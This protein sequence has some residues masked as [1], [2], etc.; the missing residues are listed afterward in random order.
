MKTKTPTHQQTIHIGLHHSK[1]ILLK[2]KTGVRVVIMTCNMRPDDWGGRCQA[3]W[4]QDF[5]FKPPRAKSKGKEKARGKAGKRKR[6]G[7]DAAPIL[8]EEPEEEEEEG[9]DIGKK[10]R[11]GESGVAA[12]DDAGGAGSG[13]KRKRV[14]SDS[15]EDYPEEEEEEE[16]GEGDD[17]DVVITSEFE[18]ILID[19]FEHVGGPAA[20]WGRSLSAYDFSSANVTLIPSVPGRHKGKDLYRY[21]H[22]R[23][24]AVL[25]REEVHVRPGSHRVAFQAASI[26]NLSRRPYKWLGE[27]TESFMAE[28]TSSKNG[29]DGKKVIRDIDVGLAEEEEMR[30][31]KKEQNE[32]NKGENLP[33]KP[34]G[35]RKDPWG[36]KGILEKRKERADRREAI[37]RRNVLGILPP[38]KPK[39]P[40][41]LGKKALKRKKKEELEA[42]EAAALIKWVGKERK[43]NWFMK[44]LRVVWPTEEAVRTSNLGWESGS[45]MPCLTTTLYEGGYRKCETNYQLNRVMEELKP[46]LCT[47]TGAKGMNRGNAM[48][49]LN[50]YYRYRELPRTDGSLKMSKDGLAYF[51]L[52]SHSLHRIAWGYLEHRNPPQRPRKRRV[53]MKPIYPP[54]PDNTLPYKEEEAQLDIK[55][56]DMGVMFLPSKI[57]PKRPL[58]MDY[59]SDD[60]DD[61]TGMGAAGG[62]GSGA[63]S[64]APFSCD[65]EG[66]LFRLRPLSYRCPDQAPAAR[67]KTLPLGLLP[68]PHQL[69]G[70]PA[71]GV[72]IVFVPHTPVSWRLACQDVWFAAVLLSRSS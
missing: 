21:G 44:F 22:M 3:A 6:V 57:P 59:D 25:A 70:E 4:Y 29:K 43:R 14:D 52:A 58:P 64:P 20:V 10:K 46:L 33:K 72:G 32:R 54:K 24:R 65:P 66:A 31:K 62:G 41:R 42:A 45:G 68:L 50:T 63:A 35:Q 60:S 15:E 12:A 2:Y 16:E 61:D 71:G 1:M 27:I 8:D 37:H 53:R 26:M 36:D 18:E 39:P 47:W 56:F 9:G 49:H 19:Y 7:A 30:R 38:K 23:V 17:D 34:L 40:K 11:R 28:K 69:P 48:P 51:L 67:L 5:P 55:S 13:G